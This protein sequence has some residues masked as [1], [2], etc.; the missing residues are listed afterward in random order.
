MRSADFGIRMFDFGFIW[1]GALP[2]I[3]SGQAVPLPGGGAVDLCC[4]RGG[5][6]AML[7]RKTTWFGA[8]SLPPLIAF[9]FP[10]R[11]TPNAVKHA[12]FQVY[13][14]FTFYNILIASVL[15]GGLQE[16]FTVYPE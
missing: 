7:S 8:L 16:G 6:A 1:F 12:D 10:T 14:I 15:I 3:N 9:H 13:V 5:F 4:G 11:N 2:E